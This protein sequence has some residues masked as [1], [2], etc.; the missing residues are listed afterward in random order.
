M[1]ELPEVETVRRGLNKLTLAQ[2][3]QGGDVLLERSIAHPLSVNG[4]LAP[5][6]HVTITTWQ[7]RGKY[8]LAQLTKLDKSEAGWLGVHLRMTGQLL[9]LNQDEPLQKHARVRLFFP[10]GKELRFVDIRTFG[11]MW[12]VPPREAPENIITGLKRLGP[13]PFSPEFSTEYLVSKLQN[14][15]ISIKTALLDQALV[16][17]VGN[18]YADEALFLAGVMPKTPCG[19]LQTEQIDGLRIAII[20][21]LQKGIDSGGTSFSNFL[22]VLGVN[23]NYTGLAW[24]YGRRGQPCRVCGTPIERLKLGGRSS[25]FCPSC[26]PEKA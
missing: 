4:F 10:D 1:P 25:H 6:K 16:A 20:Q 21:V 3:I 19:A 14:R 12:W 24:V 5:L 7:R 8:L 17:G 2:E 9:W 23:G 26:Q 18:I 22:N 11:K 13:E 15:Q